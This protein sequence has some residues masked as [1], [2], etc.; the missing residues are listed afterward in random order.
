ME[1]WHTKEEKPELNRQIYIVYINNIIAS[2]IVKRD[3]IELYKDIQWEDILTD[4][5]VIQW[6]Y[7]ENIDTLKQ[8]L[9][10]K[11]EEI[12]E[13]NEKIGKD[14][15]VDYHYH[16]NREFELLKEI[17]ELKNKENRSDGIIGGLLNEGKSLQT[18]LQQAKEGL[19]FYAKAKHFE[20]HSYYDIM[21]EWGEKARETL[22][23]INKE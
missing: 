2:E 14:N 1:I 23:M 16:R 18:K 13:L 19:E 6:A 11:D 10:A 7:I 3:I 17:E 21:L 20:E 4:W 22:E 15:V 12:K 8:Q 9:Q 5:T